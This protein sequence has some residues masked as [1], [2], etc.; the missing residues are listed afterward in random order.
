MFR[1]VLVSDDKQ[2]Y[3]QLSQK[4][5]SLNFTSKI[6]RCD[7][8]K[9]ILVK[10]DLIIID[11]DYIK[12][13]NKDN[14]N[15]P[16]M[17]LSKEAWSCDSQVCQN[18]LIKTYMLGGIDLIM[19]PIND[20][21]IEKI[22]RYLLNKSNEIITDYHMQGEVTISFSKILTRDLKGAKRGNYPYS[23]I[24]LKLYT[25]VDIEDIKN[26]LTASFRE[27]DTP[28]V[29]SENIIVISMPFCDLEG[30][31]V[32]SNKVTKLINEKFKINAIVVGATND[33]EIDDPTVLLDDCLSRLQNNSNF[34]SV[35]N[36]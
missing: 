19:N 33:N 17:L 27:T 25:K 24:A 26:Y 30:I 22:K 15:Y 8:F 20:I 28:L 1:I 6:I 11:L 18:Y 29:Y 31:V 5:N 7:D 12:V 34:I 32:V 16:F 9:N 13:E 36:L 14:I 2:A 10:P 21:G 3:I 35:S 4:C 23:I